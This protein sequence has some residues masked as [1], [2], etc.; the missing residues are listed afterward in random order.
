MSD[1]AIELCRYGCSLDEA[2]WRTVYQ[3][4]QLCGWA[5]FNACAANNGVGEA[6][7][8]YGEDADTYCITTKD[9]TSNC[10]INKSTTSPS[11]TSHTTI[12]A[13]DETS[14]A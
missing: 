14:A 13:H 9:D 6:E 2:A 12:Y 10:T 7:N 5:S 1:A 8:L 3:W 4:Y 11:V